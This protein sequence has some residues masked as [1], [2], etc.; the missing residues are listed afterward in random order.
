MIFFLS[1]AFS[2]LVGSSICWNC[3]IFW[4]ELIIYDSFPVLPYT[5]Q[6]LLWVKTSLLCGWWL[7][8]SLAPWSLLFHIIVQYSIHFSSPVLKIKTFTLCFSRK[9]HVEIQSRKFFSVNL[10]EKPKHQ[11]DGHNQ[12]SANDFQSLIW[13]FWV[14]WSWYSVDCSQ[15]MSWFDHFQLQLVY[16]TLEHYPKSWNFIK[17][18]HE[19]SQTIFDSFDQSQHL[20]YTLHKSLFVCLFWL[21]FYLF[22]KNKSY[23][24]ENAA[25]SFHLQY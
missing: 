20:L 25:F 11:S 19:T 10:C 23:Y 9:L 13:M 21:C 17:L 24:P 14:C 2:Y 16:L 18:E 15:L 3:L 12:T 6:H 1:S 7:V 5:K 4:K 8:I 22:W